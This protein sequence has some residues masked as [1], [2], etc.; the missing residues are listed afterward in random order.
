MLPTTTPS[1]TTTTTLHYTQL[2]YSTPQLQL[3][4]QLHHTTTTTTLHYSTVPYINSISLRYTARLH[5]TTLRYAARHSLHHHQY[6]CN[7]TKLI[8]LHHNY[9]STTLQL[10]LQL[11]YTTLHPAVLGEVTT[12]T[13][14]TTPKKNTTP[15]TFQSISECALSSVDHNNQPL[16]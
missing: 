6:D 1:S 7:N 8:T 9:N 14:A 16:L 15:T 5:Y 2:H 11:H 12:A 4:L 10:E 13:V 3:Q